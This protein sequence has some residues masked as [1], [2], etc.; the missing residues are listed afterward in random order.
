M[1]GAGSRDE[2]H[3]S[4]AGGQL[5]AKQISGHISHASG[6]DELLALLVVGEAHAQD[7]IAE[8]AVKLRALLAGGTDRRRL[9]PTPSRQAVAADARAQEGLAEDADRAPC[10]PAR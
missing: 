7:V 3:T 5:N 9:G 6:A 4:A 1:R 2:R 10:A 8:E